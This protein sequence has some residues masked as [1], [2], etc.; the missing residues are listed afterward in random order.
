MIVNGDSFMRMLLKW[1]YSLKEIVN[2]PL[3]DS[4]YPIVNMK[5]GYTNSPTSILKHDC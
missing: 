2:V 4:G 5:S 1:V 3:S